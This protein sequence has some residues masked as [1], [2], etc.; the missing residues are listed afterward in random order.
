MSGTESGSIEDQIYAIRERIRELEDKIAEVKAE[1][2]EYHQRRNALRDELQRIRERV[3]ELKAEKI[4]LLE[5]ARQLR[6]E[7]R[8]LREELLNAVFEVRSKRGEI[9]GTLKRIDVERIRKRL[10]EIDLY[11]AAHRVRREEERRLFEEASRLEAMLNEYERALR[12]NEELLKMYPE[13]EAKKRALDE[14]RAELE[15]LNNRISAITSE[16]NSLNARYDMLKAELDEVRQKYTQVKNVWDRYEAE[17]ILLASRVFDLRRALRAEREEYLKRRISAIKERKK[18]EALEKLS[19]GEKVDFEELK[20]LVDDDEI[21]EVFK[22]AE[23][24]A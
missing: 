12:I 13:I 7:V 1:A 21:F 11:L 8:R 24:G 5:K 4:A 10:D 15:E 6:G 9:K 16:L 14:K 22:S 20:L 3:A 2:L 19:R 18:R 17:V 23:E